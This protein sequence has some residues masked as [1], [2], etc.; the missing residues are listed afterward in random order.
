MKQAVALMASAGMVW[1]K[2]RG[3]RNQLINVLITYDDCIG[4]LT[5]G[6]W[7]NPTYQIQATHIFGLWWWKRVWRVWM[8]NYVIQHSIGYDYLSMPKIPASGDKVL[9]YWL[10]RAKGETQRH[11]NKFIQHSMTMYRCIIS[12]THMTFSLA[13]TRYQLIICMLGDLY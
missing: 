11:R 4:M 1:R 7:L 13:L 2:E 8:S 5:T 9:I 10:D 3:V 6:I 12:D